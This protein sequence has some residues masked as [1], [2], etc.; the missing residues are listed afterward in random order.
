MTVRNNNGASGQQGF[1]LIELVVVIA[2]MGVLAAIVI[3]VVTRH[4]GESQE[5]TYNAQ[6]QILQGVVDQYVVDT[7]NPLF[8]G[9]TQL[10]IFGAAKGTG[11]YYEGDGDS[12]AELIAGAI[13]NPLAGTVGGTPIWADDGSG[14]REQ[15]S[16]D[17]LNDEDTATSV[18]GWHVRQVVVVGVTNYVDTRDYFV[19]FDLLLNKDGEGFLRVPPDSASKDNCSVSTCTGSYIYYVDEVGTLE[20]LLTSFPATSTKGFQTGVFP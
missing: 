1:T 16:E 2:I 18:V 5:E 6:K 11:P 20:T 12:T 4:L 15:P 3:P 13:A 14:A 10:P 7:N 8:Q 17:V 9:R 19:D